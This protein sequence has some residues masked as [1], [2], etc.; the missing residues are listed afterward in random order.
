MPLST[1]AHL[2]EQLCVLEKAGGGF[3]ISQTKEPG[4]SGSWWRDQGAPSS[5]ARHTQQQTPDIWQDAPGDSEEPPQH[6]TLE[7]IHVMAS[8]QR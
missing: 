1:C 6:K 4:A 3:T 8:L 2:T 7:F 5:L